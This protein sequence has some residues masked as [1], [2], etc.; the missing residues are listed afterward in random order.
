MLDLGSGSGLTAIACALA[1]ASA[2]L[3]SELDPFA[4]AA[5]ELNASGERRVHRRDR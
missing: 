1:G 3:A 2:V 4:L 5:I